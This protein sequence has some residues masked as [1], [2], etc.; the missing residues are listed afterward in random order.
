MKDLRANVLE[1]RHDRLDVG[2][3]VDEVDIVVQMET[4]GAEHCDE[5]LGVLEAEYR[6][7]SPSISHDFG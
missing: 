7:V 6:V 3:G 1:V 5:V 4:R 2:L